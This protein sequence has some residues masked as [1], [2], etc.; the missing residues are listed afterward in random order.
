MR[1]RQV[2]SRFHHTS[3]R[4][5]NPHDSYDALDIACRARSNPKAPRGEK[6]SMKRFVWGVVGLFALGWSGLAFAQANTIATACPTNFTC[7]FS[8]AETLS[9]LVSKGATTV[10]GQPDVFIGY[11]VFDGS[12]N[13]TLTGMQN[14]DGT[15]TQ[16]GGANGLTSTKACTNGTGGQPAIVDLS[17]NSELALVIDSSGNELQFILTKDTTT[18]GKSTTAN[19]VRIGVCRKQ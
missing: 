9:L 17:D 3:S 4:G 13:V 14:L 8:A 2:R 18:G 1:G 19:S 11:M 12:S 6:F 16:I 5:K 15:I 10:P 7:A